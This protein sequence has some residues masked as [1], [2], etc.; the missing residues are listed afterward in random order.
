MK[1]SIRLVLIVVGFMTDISIVFAEQESCQHAA[2]VTA[3]ENLL[4]DKNAD[5]L[6]VKTK[7]VS[8]SGQS[9][10]DLKKKNKAL[11]VLKKMTLTG[12]R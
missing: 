10:E 1:N 8:V 9:A 4:H 12:N 6:N 7:D 3:L 11:E 5:K 2:L